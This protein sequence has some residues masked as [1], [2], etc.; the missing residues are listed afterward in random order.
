MASEPRSVQARA[1]PTTSGRG[2]KAFAQCGRGATLVEFALLAPMLMVL[3][4]GIIGYGGYFYL[5]HTVQELANDA[6]RA[7]VGGLTST[8]RQ[9]LA[10]QAVTLDLQSYGYLSSNSTSVQVNDS[11]GA[12]LTVQVAYNAAHD[13]LYGLQGLVPLPSSTI[14]RAASISL[15]GF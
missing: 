10:T 8:E 13:P 3:L 12:S 7:A 5:S 1:R 11:N 2:I 4:M 15:G 6:A 14:S 9:S